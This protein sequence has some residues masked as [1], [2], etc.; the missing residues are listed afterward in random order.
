MDLGLT[1]PL[2][3]SG[4]VD[5]R[6]AKDMDCEVSIDSNNKVVNRTQADN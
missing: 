6:Y 4:A 3:K 5:K 2:D 1:L